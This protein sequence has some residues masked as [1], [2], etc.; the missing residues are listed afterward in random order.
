MFAGVF[1]LPFSRLFL[2]DPTSGYMGDGLIIAGAAAV[3]CADVLF[4]CGFA[5]L[6][7]AWWQDEIWEERMRLSSLRVVGWLLLIIVGA[8]FA[9]VPFGVFPLAGFVA[10]WR[11]VGGIVLAFLL[12]IHFLDPRVFVAALVVAFGMQSLIA[13]AQFAIGGSIGLGFLGESGFNVTTLNVAK[14]A[15]ETGATVVRAMGTLPHANVLGGLCA[16]VLLC[17]FGVRGVG[18]GVSTALRWKVFNALLIALLTTGVFLSFSRSA[19]MVAIFGALM[20]TFLNFRARWRDMLIVMLVMLVF[21]LSFVPL[22]VSRVGEG[23]SAGLTRVAQLTLVPELVRAYPFGA[24][25]GGSAVAIGVLHPELPVYARVPPH[26]F[27]AVILVEQSIFVL[28]VWLALLCVLV[29]QLIRTHNWRG[30]VLV[31]AL[32]ALAQTD[33]YFLTTVAG[34]WMFAATI[35]FALTPDSSSS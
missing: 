13:I 2:L 15:T 3:T 33:H 5:C 1:A 20:L 27:F 29:W 14:I 32:L 35:G 19:W 30:L 10:A 8:T 16:L 9:L 23:V 22:V 34:M 26:N 31:G 28:A 24:G 21:A 18:C 12:A 11:L 17:W 4:I 6:G 7:I 25:I